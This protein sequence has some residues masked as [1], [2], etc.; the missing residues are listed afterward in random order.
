MATNLP[1]AQNLVR[2]VF[3]INN[4]ETFGEIAR[5]VF[6]FQ[7]AHIPVYKTFCDLVHRKPEHV[8]QIEEIPF[9][10]ISFFK[11]HKVLAESTAP[12][13][14]FESSGT[15]GMIPSRH[16]V[17]SG[18]V[19]E[20]SFLRCFEAFYGPVSGYCILGLLPSYLERGGSSL[21]YMVNDLIQRSGHP[22]SGFYL[23]DLE[24]LH[25]TLHDLEQK[26]QKTLLIGVTYALLDFAEAFPMPLH[27]T[28]IMETGGMKGRKQE[29]VREEVHSLLK[30]AFGVQEVHSEYGMTELLS[31]AY[32][33]QNGRFYT[34]PWMQVLIREEDDPFALHRQGTGAVNIIDLAN[35]FSCSFIATEDVGRA[36]PDKG[37]EI[38]G[39]IDHSDIRGCSLLAI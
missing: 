2:E 9:L 10:P 23:H 16:Y 26:G 38:I 34:P 4:E 28:I 6:A 25:S 29:L 36:F 15:T 5:R 37:F 17:Q 24:S 21:V 8:K 33:R 12:E 13:I 39:R 1:K 20:K 27:H 19:Y 32:A 22:D 35:V 3:A 18:Q 7:Y 14:I 11:T 30:G 31:Q